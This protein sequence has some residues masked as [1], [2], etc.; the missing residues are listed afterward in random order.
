MA[1][2]CP[3]CNH[4][5]EREDGYWVTA[6]IVNT[7]V[8]EVLFAALFVGTIFATLPEIQWGPLLVVGAFTNVAFPIFFYPLSKTLWV[9]IDLHFHPP[10]KDGRAPG[11]IPH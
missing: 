4:V 10:S 3:R 5:Y 11:R 8:T 9:A 7:A 2:R 6:I 1:A